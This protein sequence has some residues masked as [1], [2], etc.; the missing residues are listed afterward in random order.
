MKILK[1]VKGS[2]LWLFENNPIT[3]KNL[4]QEANKRDVGSD[5]LIFAKPMALDKHLARHKVADLFLDTFPYTAHTTCSDALWAGLP[6]L[7]CTG[8]SFASR[9]SA[10]LLNAIG[11]SELVTHTHKEY[12]GMAIELANNLI[13]LKEIKNELEKNKLEK[14]LFNTKLFTKHIESAYTE[15]HKKYIKNK[16]P[17]H[18]KI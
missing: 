8:E 17:D 16:K 7:T 14:P 13:R 1:K 15:I 18:I 3:I 5:R 12:E 4:Q 10:S 11:L 6:V 2:V 9:V